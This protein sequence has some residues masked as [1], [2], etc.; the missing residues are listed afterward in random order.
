MNTVQRHTRCSAA[1]CLRKR[2]G[3]QE[4]KCRFDYPRPQLDKSTLEFELLK[5]G[6]VR[7]VLS[8]RR[9]DPRVNSHSRVMIQHW[10]A[11]VD[12]Q[13]IVDAQACARYMAKYASKGEPRSQSVSS[14]FKSC[15]QRLTDESHSHTVFKSAVIKSI[16]ERDFSAQETAHQL[17]S[18]PLISCT[19]NFVALSLDNSR[20][21]TKNEQSGEQ[22]LNPSLLD[23]YGL[24]SELHD[25]NLIE[26]V[27]TNT[28]HN[29]E[30]KKRT[31]EVIVRTFPQY[32]SNPR[33]Q[34]YGRYCKY[35]L[36]Q[37][38]PWSGSP[39]NS[40]GDVSDTDSNCIAA[41]HNFLSTPAATKCPQ[42]SQDLDQAQ[43]YLAENEDSDS[44][45]DEPTQIEH[46]EEWMLLCRLHQQ[47]SSSTS[48]DTNDIE[49]A[50]A[51]PPE[52][53]RQCPSWVSIK[54]KDAIDDPQSS[55]WLRRL[56]AVNINTLNQQHSF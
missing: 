9:N 12:L 1:Y 8:T 46:H 51:L 30:L 11:N 14:I 22:F 32:S 29:G 34:H 19:F 24:R 18:L 17:L 54:R 21:L 39:A 28:F 48:E 10:R 33:G 47:Y 36:I 20:S 53:L 35:Q 16:G 40:W 25:I 26:F 56:P 5:D 50:E 2:S 55:I 45:T 43:H 7:A 27:S 44:E 3:Q 42:F 38:K 49:A 37:Y 31:T 6:C 23:H 13:V 15:V 4:P 52:T 41:Y